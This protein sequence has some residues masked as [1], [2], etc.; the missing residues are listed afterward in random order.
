ME[1]ASESGR[2]AVRASLPALCWAFFKLGAVTFGGMWA[3]TTQLETELADRRGWIRKEELP[4]LLVAATLIPAPKFMGLGGLIGYKLRGVAGSA[5]A[6]LSLVLPGALMVVAVVVLVRSDLL[7]GYMAPVQAAVGI[8]VAG[9]TF[10]SALRQL[11]NAKQTGRNRWVG[12][13]LAAAVAVAIA[14]GVPLLVAAG[15]GFTVG[16]LAMRGE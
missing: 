4:F 6:A 10:G 7:A 16:V 5:L 13:L 2:P 9:I 14:A 12:L 15:A 1:T 11:R 3:A 8:G